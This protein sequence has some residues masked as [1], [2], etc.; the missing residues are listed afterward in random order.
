VAALTQPRTPD[1]AYA[2]R[3]PIRVV[4]A[5]DNLILRQGVRSLLELAD[6]TTPHNATTRPTALS[7]QRIVL[8]WPPTRSDRRRV[9]D[10]CRSAANQNGH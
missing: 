10:R 3:M 4:L 9:A 8:S 2:S 5:E 6:Q 1:A 7:R